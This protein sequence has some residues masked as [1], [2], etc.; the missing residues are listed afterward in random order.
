[1]NTPDFSPSAEQNKHPILEKLRQ[2]LPAQGAA[3]EIASG[4]G[5]HAAWFASHLPGWRWQPTDA[6]PGSLPSIRAHVAQAGLGNVLEPS[7]LDVCADVWLPACPSATGAP[8]FDLIF[9]AN[10]LH[11]SP[12]ETGPALM[13]GSARHL[14]PGGLLVT[15]GPYFEHDV[16]TAASNL[17]F[18][19]SLRQRNP[20]WGVRQREDLERAAQTFGL[21]LAERHTMPA[22][23]LLL[24]WRRAFTRS[25]P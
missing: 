6:Q 5:Q 16:P 8:H 12:K 17:A 10:M 25:S 1:M 15:Y 20:A 14:A 22:N 13:R 4:T 9:C 18:D 21:Q 11:I 19:E 3:L 2:L 23:N 7:L 24:V